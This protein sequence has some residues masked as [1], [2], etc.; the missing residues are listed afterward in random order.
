MIL[1]NALLCHALHQLCFMQHQFV[2]RSHCSGKRS[3]IDSWWISFSAARDALTR[4]QNLLV[5][6]VQESR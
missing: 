4:M 2:D 6:D 3:L 1:L 5:S